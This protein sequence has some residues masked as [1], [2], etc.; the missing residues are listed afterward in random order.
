MSNTILGLHHGTITPQ[1]Q[2][3]HGGVYDKRIWCAEIRSRPSACCSA[4]LEAKRHALEPNCLY[5]STLPLYGNTTEH[6]CGM[7]TFYY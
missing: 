7:S 2:I 3:A 1:L 4:Q 5:K 6:S